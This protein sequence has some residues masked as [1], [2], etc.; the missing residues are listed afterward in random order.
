MR[1]VPHEEREATLPFWQQPLLAA[2]RNRSHDDARSA[3]CAM[4]KRFDRDLTKKSRLFQV[5]SNQL[6]SLPPELG[7]LTNLKRLY[8]RHSRQMDLDLTLRQLGSRS[9]MCDT[10]IEWSLTS[11][12]DAWALTA[13]LISF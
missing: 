4:S 1:V 11:L 3:L 10:R 13:L 9:S 12:C 5:S 7:L 8:V 6:M 2:E